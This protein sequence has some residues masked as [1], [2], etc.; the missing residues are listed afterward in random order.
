MGPDRIVDHLRAIRDPRMRVLALVQALGEGDPVAWVEV[1]ATIVTRAHTLADADALLAVQALIQAAAEPTL[2]YAARKAIYE[3]A[4]ARAA[5]SI[6][7][8]FL[9]VSPNVPP[10][11]A[12]GR[13]AASRAKQ[14][15][16]ERPLRPAGRPLSLGERKALARTHDREELLL[17]L[18]DPHPDVVAIILGNPHVTESDVLRLASARPAV[19][20]ALAKIA[21]HARWNVRHGVK[22]ALVLNPS[23]PL[24]TAMRIATTLRPGELAELADDP[25]IAAPLREHAAQVRA[26]TRRRPQA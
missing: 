10:S 23:T 4:I 18:R 9:E 5:P 20:A 2:I 3:A 24:A 12:G 15:A 26:A 1:I 16:P 22:R 13:A 6:A 19:P 21:A 25:S 11:P 7:R 17:L 14:L 8:L